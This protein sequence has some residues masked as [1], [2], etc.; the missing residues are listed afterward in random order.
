MT[1]RLDPVRRVLVERVK[2]HVPASLWARL[3]RLAPTAPPP[4]RTAR[5]ERAL[6]LR[7]MTVTELAQEFGSDKW[8]VHR[9]T[10]HY[11]HH[12][13]GLRERATS[14]WSSGSAAMP[15]TSRAARR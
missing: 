15:A 7:S 1:A 11:E 6:R 10:P 13:A 8:G 5:Q 3:R 14:S 12:F 9:Y 4:P 2:P